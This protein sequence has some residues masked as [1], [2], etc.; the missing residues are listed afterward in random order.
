M[1]QHS[2]V[3]LALYGGIG[4]VAGL[5]AGLLGVGGGLVIVPALT[6]LF[7]AQGFPRQGGIQLAL[8]TSLASILF[9]SLSSAR[10][11]HRNGFV[12]WSLVKRITPGILVGTYLGG[13]LASRLDSTVLK[14]VFTVFLFT[15]ALQM[16]SGAKTRP[17]RTLPGVSGTTGVGLVIGGVSSWV[18][19][20]GGSMSVPFMLWCNVEPR[21]AVGTSAAIGFP[22]AFAG[23]LTYVVNGLGARTVVPHAIGYIHL[24][25]LV[26]VSVVSMIMAPFGACLA[27]R[28]DPV[29]VK[30]WFAGFLLVV[31]AKLLYSL[32]TG[33]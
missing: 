2:L 19:I 28:L 5:L 29:R 31:A 22:I 33:G 27:S 1:D 32:S 3:F 14:I 10:A 13:L 12:D 4:M 30:R 21:R 24:P 7:E 6:Y 9:T 18:G 17:T 11:H 8:G 20:G 23:A 25:A 26:G 16:L 15:V